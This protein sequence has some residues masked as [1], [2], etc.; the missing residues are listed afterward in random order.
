[1]SANIRL[2]NVEPPNRP[3]QPIEYGSDNI[4]T[5]TFY[6]SDEKAPLIPVRD[7]SHRMDAKRDPNIETKTYGMFSNCCKGE[8]KAIVTEGIKIQFFCT[9]RGNP[10][11]RVLTGYY[12]PK[13]YCELAPNDFAIAAETIRFVSPGFVLSDIVQYMGYPIADF[14]R[15]WKHIRG[16]KAI[17]RLKL[18]I[19]S[20]ADATIDYLNEMNRLEQNA[21]ND[22][23][24]M[25]FDRQNGLTWEYAHELFQ[26]RGIL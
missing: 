13:W 26:K 20:A 16:K 1:L 14:F 18:L 6:Y 8:R 10:R 9:S 23:G 19:D 11:A 4:A 7:V 25:Y 22:Y 12:I 3:W 2:Q 17:D 21:L 5:I 24:R 15:T